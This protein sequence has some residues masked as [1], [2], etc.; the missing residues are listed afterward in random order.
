MRC[1]RDDGGG[2]GGGAGVAA[3]AAAADGRAFELAGREAEE[4]GAGTA[5]LAVLS[6][7]ILVCPR[8]CVVTDSDS[9]VDYSTKHTR[10]PLCRPHG[11]RPR[12]LSSIGGSPRP[13]GARG[14]R[15]TRTCA[16]GDGRR[17]APRAR[18]GAQAA[19]EGGMGARRVP[20]VARRRSQ[21][22]PPSSCRPCRIQTPPRPTNSARPHRRRAS[23]SPTRDRPGRCHHAMMQPRRFGHQLRQSP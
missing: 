15:R 9:D 10:V 22:P 12:L 11:H 3:C 8:I 5:W 1:L 20:S 17:G 23:I 4:D 7:S 19:L 18:A 6:G 2:L 13:R 21:R 16:A 14:G